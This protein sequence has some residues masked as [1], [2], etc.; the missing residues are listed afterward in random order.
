V[1]AHRISTAVYRLF[2]DQYEK[3]HNLL[4]GSNGQKDGNRALRIAQDMKLDIDAINEES[5]KSSVLGAF[6][7]VNDLANKLGINGTPSYV[8]GDEVVF[9]ALGE[10]VLREKIQNVRKCGKTVCS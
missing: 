2:P 7:E 10:Q 4:L 6:R 8:I 1:E 9:G 5:K 3:F